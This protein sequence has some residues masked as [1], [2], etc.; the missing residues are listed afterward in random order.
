MGRLTAWRTAC[1]LVGFWVGGLGGSAAAA[2]PVR[3]QLNGFAGP[4]G[5]ISVQHS[6]DTVD[7]YFAL[8]ALLLA[9]EF[10]LDISAYA[11]PWAQWLLARQ[12]PDATFDRFCRRGPVWAPCKTADADDT[13]LALWLRLV[14]SLPP[15]LNTQAPWRASHRISSEALARL[16]DRE[17]GIY[18]V[19]PVYPHGLLMDNL[20]V[21]SYQAACR[22]DCPAVKA[23]SKRLA[24]AIHTTFWDRAARRFLVSTQPEQKTVAATF[25]PEHVGQLY[26]LLFD[27]QLLGLHPHTHYRDWMREHRA[28]WLAQSQHD[29]AWGLVALVALKFDDRASA[30]CWLRESAHARGGAHWIVTDEVVQQILQSRAVAPASAQAWCG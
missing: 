11:Q 17:R 22:H 16:M 12:K 5:A 28:S 8:Q 21:L 25:Y 4:E 2:P 13:L 24:E 7:P 9:R 3:L 30:A 15:A 26:P 27:F 10:G 1:W 23:R 6:G 20:E 18:L 29:F 14:D 19:S